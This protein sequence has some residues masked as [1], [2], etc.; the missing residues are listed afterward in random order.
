MTRAITTGAKEDVESMQGRGGVGLKGQTKQWTL[1]QGTASHFKVSF[2]N[3]DHHHFNNHSHAIIVTMTTKLPLYLT[4][5]MTCL[6]QTKPSPQHEHRKTMSSCRQ[7][8]DAFMSHS[9]IHVLFLFMHQ[10]L[11]FALLRSKTED[12]N[13]WKCHKFYHHGVFSVEVIF[14]EIALTVKG[15]IK[16]C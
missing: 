4:Q 10:R 12:V 9:N 13:S 16:W 5:T 8:E 1:T 6:K 2:F 3:Q 14:A 15:K 7:E 11:C